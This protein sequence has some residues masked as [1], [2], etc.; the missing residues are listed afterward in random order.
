MFVNNI[1]FLFCV[2]LSAY[3]LA[4][5]V[6]ER[7]SSHTSIQIVTN[8]TEIGPGPLDKGN[9]AIGGIY[10]DDTQEEVLKKLG[11][12]TEKGIE[13]STPFPQWYYKDLNMYVSFFSNGSPNAKVGG[14]VRIIV[15]SPSTDKT[16]TNYGFGIGD[17]VGSLEKSFRK[18]YAY[19]PRED[20][21]TQT[22]YITGEEKQGDQYLPSLMILT[23]NNVIDRMVL[24]NE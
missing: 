11:E 4:G 9:I 12:P 14:V 8:S 3:L 22:L 13:H 2:I 5:C 15:N 18:I 10:L 21:Q 19:E 24:S 23:K 7:E 17:K 16:K 6:T 20:T 1:R